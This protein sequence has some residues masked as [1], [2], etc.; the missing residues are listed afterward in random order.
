MTSLLQRTPANIRI[1][2]FCQRLASLGF[3]SID[4]SMG[5]SSFTLFVVDFK[6]HVC[7]AT[8][9]IMAVQ[10]QFRVNQDLVLGRWFYF[11]TNQKRVCDFLLVFNSNFSPT[12]D[13]FGD[14][15][16]Y[17]YP[18]N[19]HLTPSLLTTFSNFGKNLIFAKITKS[20]RNVYWWRK[21]DAIALLIFTPHALR[22]YVQCKKY[23]HRCHVIEVPS[24]EN[25][26]I[27]D[28]EIGHNLKYS[29]CRPKIQY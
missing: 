24:T 26:P 27:S 12:L 13:S 18:P 25:N 16:A 11:G 8:E 6:R 17:R 21:H 15:V 4:D 29:L 10:G 3:I 9:S 22:S 14:T 2:L 20:L 23:I 28:M 7:K 1:T 19:T 5:L